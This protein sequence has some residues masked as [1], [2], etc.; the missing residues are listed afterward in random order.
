[1]RGPTPV[2]PSASYVEWADL[3]A[4]TVTKRSDGSISTHVPNAPT[5]LDLALSDGAVYV[6]FEGRSNLAGRVVDVYSLRDGKYR[7]SFLLPERSS[8]MTVYDGVLY[9]I[10]Y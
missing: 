3:P 2:V 7:H 5:A 8:T 6:L 4:P 1:M 10:T 9:L